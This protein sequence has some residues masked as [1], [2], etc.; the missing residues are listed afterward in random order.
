M[1]TTR[2]QIGGVEHVWRTDGPLPGARAGVLPLSTEAQ[3]RFGTLL[4]QLSYL[5]SVLQ[6]LGIPWFVVGG[7]LLGAVRHHGFIPYDDD[8]DLCI[9]VEHHQTL[10]DFCRRVPTGEFRVQPGAHMDFSCAGA[11][12]YPGI[13]IFTLGVQGGQRRYAFPVRRGRPL[14]YMSHVF[15]RWTFE[16]D[17]FDH[18]VPHPF[19]QL[20]VWVPGDATAVLRRV[21]GPDVLVHYVPDARPA[22]LHPVSKLA[23]DSGLFPSVVYGLLAFSDETGLSAHP[24][25]RAHLGLLV[26][27]ALCQP[28][29]HNQSPRS[30][31]DTWATLLGDFHRLNFGAVRQ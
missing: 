17:V 30:L 29:R 1:Y 7:T 9:P 15:P 26:T 8:I 23:I 10:L 22:L 16:S 27:M 25:S 14:Y 4:A 24:D 28:V 6:S 3:G 2:Y 19:E 5:S 18:L 12:S 31:V 20:T 13:D 21:Y 11:A